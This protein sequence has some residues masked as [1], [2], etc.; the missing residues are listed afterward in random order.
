MNYNSF[1]PSSFYFQ[2]LSLPKTSFRSRYGHY[3]YLVMLFC[4][5]NAIIGDVFRSSFVS[6]ATRDTFGSHCYFLGVICRNIEEDFLSKLE[7][8]FSSN[9]NRDILNVSFL[10]MY[11]N[12]LKQ[13]WG[14]ILYIRGF[15]FLL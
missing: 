8:S 5:T 2:D 13:G 14:K 7:D 1:G 3:T 6:N 11:A 15:I 9:H 10:R 4:V 12:H